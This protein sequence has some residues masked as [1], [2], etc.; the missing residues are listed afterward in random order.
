MVV[1]NEGRQLFRSAFTVAVMVVAIGAIGVL[2]PELV[3]AQTEAKTE[4]KTMR[5]SGQN[6]VPVYEGWEENPDGSFNLLFGY[7]NRNH[8]EEPDIPIGENNYFTGPAGFD[9]V[10]IGQPTHFFPQRNRWVWRFRVP[11]DFGDKELV[12]TL[13]MNGK[14]E[15]TYGTLNPGYFVDDIV[16]MNNNGAGGSGGGAGNLEGQEAPKLTVE[17]EKMRHASVGQ[18]VTLTALVTDDGRPKARGVLAGFSQRRP[19][20]RLSLGVR[21]CADSTTGLRFNWF[22]YRGPETMKFE[23]KQFDQWENYRDAADS[24]FSAGWQRPEVPED[25][26]WMTK[27]TFTEPGEYVLRAMAH[28]GGLMAWEDVTFVVE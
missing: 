2:S 19:E 14:T 24:P 4:V 22:V 7:F 11:S 18:T 16:I 21:C 12:W 15:K 10:D 26:K 23:P 28:D 17:G 25:G 9:S 5:L 27:V 3:S 13:T 6:V 1:A 8:L 20:R